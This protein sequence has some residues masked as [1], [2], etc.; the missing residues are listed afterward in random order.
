MHEGERG[1]LTGAHERRDDQAEKKKKGQTLNQCA[2]PVAGST[3]PSASNAIILPKVN[4]VTTIRE[5]LRR[6]L[7]DDQELRS[8]KARCRAVTAM[9]N[10]VVGDWST[11]FRTANLSRLPRG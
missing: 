3:T 1:L 11:C 2:M 4:N 10:D 7:I 9:F 6:I 5:R 8:F